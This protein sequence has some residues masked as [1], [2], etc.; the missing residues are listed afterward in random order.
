ML[1]GLVLVGG[2]VLTLLNGYLGPGLGDQAQHF[3]TCSAT[4]G[5]IAD[6]HELEGGLE[7]VETLE[8]PEMLEAIEEMLETIEE[9]IE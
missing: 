6:A 1:A 7:V 4:D 9:V 3:C 2:F 8:T 5:G